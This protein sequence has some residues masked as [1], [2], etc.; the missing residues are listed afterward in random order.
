[1]FRFEHELSGSGILKAGQP[2]LLVFRKQ[3][4]KIRF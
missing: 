3:K 4:Q 1:M 2:E